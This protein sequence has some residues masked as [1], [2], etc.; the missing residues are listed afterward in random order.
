MQV[1]PNQSNN[2]EETR[3]CADHEA[4]IDQTEIFHIFVLLQEDLWEKQAAESAVC[5]SGT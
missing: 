3:D 5:F 1:I 2:G 4:A